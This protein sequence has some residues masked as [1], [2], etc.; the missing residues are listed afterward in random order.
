MHGGYKRPADTNRVFP[1]V[2]CVPSQPVKLRSDANTLA[3]RGD[4][5]G[6]ELPTFLEQDSL[7]PEKCIEVVR[8]DCHDT[9]CFDTPT[10]LYV[11]STE[12]TGCDAEYSVHYDKATREFDAFPRHFAVH[13]PFVKDNVV[14]GLSAVS[15]II[16]YVRQFEGDSARKQFCS[17]QAELLSLKRTLSQI[18][19]PHC[20][21]ARLA[22][23]RVLYFV[24]LP[25]ARTL[26]RATQRRDDLSDSEYPTHVFTAL[27]NC[28]G[29]AA[30]LWTKRM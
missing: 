6:D 29:T 26:R 20:S 8:S 16:K 11:L 13:V 1:D 30:L 21:Y 24:C 19:Q 3:V 4:G 27:E 2:S 5:H 15:A 10:E 7:S 9:N 28:Q 14:T 25:C 17:R 18:T 22:P 23:R 12:C